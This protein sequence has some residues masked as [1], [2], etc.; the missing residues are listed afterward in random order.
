MNGVE[1]LVLQ[2]IPEG[3][4]H[5]LIRF[6][7]GNIPAALKFIKETWEDLIPSYPFE[8]RFLDEDFHRSYRNIE[9]TGVLL[10]SFTILAAVIACLGL[11]GLAS[12]MVEQRTREIGIRKVLG[13]SAANVVVLLTREFF[14]CIWLANIFAWP[15]AYISMNH[16]LQTFAY[17]TRIGPDIFIF[18]GLLAFGCAILA[19]AYQALRAARANPVESLRCE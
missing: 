8:Y 19:V 7:P 9:R 16:W 12:F 4:K 11:F 3:I 6:R 5:I 17:R 1:P 14:Q 18:A 2:L 15:L 13:S 10:S